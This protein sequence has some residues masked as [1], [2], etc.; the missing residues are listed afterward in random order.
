MKLTHRTRGEGTG[1]LP[2]WFRTA[3]ERSA[4]RRKGR[5]GS[6]VLEFFPNDADSSSGPAPNQWLAAG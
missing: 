3:A 5:A 6:G 1:L 2:V 4:D